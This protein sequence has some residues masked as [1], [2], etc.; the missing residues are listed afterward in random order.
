MTLLS[1]LYYRIGENLR[2]LPGQL[3]RSHEEESETE[4]EY[5]T[6]E[7]S[8]A[9]NDL[10]ARKEIVRDML[11][12]FDAR[13]L[14]REYGRDFFDAA[15]SVETSSGHLF[16]PENLAA[17]IFNLA[18]HDEIFYRH[19][20][21]ELNRDFCA[22]KF[23][24]KLARGARV[25]IERLDN[26]LRTES[27]GIEQSRQA[28]GDCAGF[29]REIVH[30]IR[31]NLDSRAP[32]GSKMVPKVSELLVGILDT[33]CQDHNLY[34]ELIGAPPRLGPSPAWMSDNFVIDVLFDRPPNE[35]EHLVENLHTILERLLQY[36][37]PVNYVRKLEGRMRE[38]DDDIHD[39]ED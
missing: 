18:M 3:N 26:I 6:A 34:M 21:R 7:R 35:W 36:E 4:S 17:T 15:P 1:E 12:V 22:T 25:A 19:L 2:Y 11:S 5:S 30:Q 9:P 38:Y 33:V 31:Q 37:A 8:P 16:V 10:N 14:P 24:Q 32:L 20:R 28:I 13:A 27:T 23:F 29:L 39:D